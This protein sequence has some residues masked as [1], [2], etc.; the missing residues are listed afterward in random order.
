LTPLGCSVSDLIAYYERE[1]GNSVRSAE[2]K[3]TVKRLKEEEERFKS[4]GLCQSANSVYVALDVLKNRGGLLGK[5]LFLYQRSYATFEPVE[6]TELT[7]NG[8]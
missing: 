6:Y 7:A 8:T 1:Y 4:S 5:A 2:A 3:A